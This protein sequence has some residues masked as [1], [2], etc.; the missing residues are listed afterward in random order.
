MEEGYKG[1]CG[2][3]DSGVGERG[4]GEIE[5]EEDGGTHGPC[6]DASAEKREWDG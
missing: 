1:G 5:I 6:G 4:R 3:S 2:L